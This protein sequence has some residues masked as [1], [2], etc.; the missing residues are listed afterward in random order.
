LLAINGD[1][2]YAKLGV[3]NWRYLSGGDPY[4]VDLDR[5]GE[6]VSLTLPLPL[7]PGK[8][9][10]PLFALGSLVFFVCGA[11][12]ALARPDDAQVRLIGA[13]LMAARVLVSVRD[14]KR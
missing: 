7:V 3:F 1:E 12:L 14:G 8:Q 13:C 10:Y 9:Q 2:R 4:R 11:L 6:R 5:H